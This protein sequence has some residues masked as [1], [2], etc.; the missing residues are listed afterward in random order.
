MSKY[1]Q[2]RHDPV[3]EHIRGMTAAQLRRT[4]IQL[5]MEAPLIASC[6]AIAEREQNRRRRAARRSA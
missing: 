4:V 2:A 1:K 3:A 5:R 6:L